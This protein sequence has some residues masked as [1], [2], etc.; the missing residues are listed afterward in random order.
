M[1]GADDSAR[2]ELV[3]IGVAV[4]EMAVIEDAI[5][6]DWIGERLEEKLEIGFSLLIR[7]SL[8]DIDPLVMKARVLATD[9]L[10][11]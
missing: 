9:R 3:E 10:V 2:L 6:E 5:F 8:P 1:L 11:A 4:V 7:N